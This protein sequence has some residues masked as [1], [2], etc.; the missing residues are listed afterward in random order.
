MTF[1]HISHEFSNYSRHNGLHILYLTKLIVWRYLIGLTVEVEE[2]HVNFCQNVS[3]LLLIACEVEQHK[4]TKRGRKVYKQLEQQM[5]NLRNI[6]HCGN[7][8]FVISV[9]KLNKNF[10]KFNFSI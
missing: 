6:Y 7:Q 3:H 2:Y 9:T 10:F 8:V 1:L 4:K 5:V